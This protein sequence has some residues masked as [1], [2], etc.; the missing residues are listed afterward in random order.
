MRKPQR[1]NQEPRITLGERVV[2]ALLTPLLFNVAVVIALATLSQR[3]RYLLMNLGS[4]YRSLDAGAIVLLV[5]PAAVGFLAGADGTARIFGHAF[6]T[7]HENH[8]SVLATALVWAV[9]AA[10]VFWVN[11]RVAG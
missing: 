4:F 10:T 5:A 7:N 8:R 2:G 9:F 6:W 3:S 1:R 11:T